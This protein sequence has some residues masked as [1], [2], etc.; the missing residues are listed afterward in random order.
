MQFAIIALYLAVLSILGVY[1]FHRAHLV[2]LFWRYRNNRV[3]PPGEFKDL[4]VVTIQLPMYNELFVAE[5]LLESISELDYPKDKLELQVLDDSTDETSGIVAKKVAE[6]SARGFDISHMH[7]T[8]RTG[9][10]AGALEIGM[11]VARGDFLMVFDADFMPSKDIVRRLIHHFTDPKVAMVQARWDHLNRD[12]SMLTRAQALMLDGHFVIEHIARNRSGRFFNFNGTAGIWRKTA[13]IDAGGWQHDTITEDMDLSFRA[14]I[15]GWKF[16]YVPEAV[17][18]A[19]VPCEMNSFK[20]QQFRWAKGSAQT[21]KKILPM[22]L[23][24]DL[25]LRI[26]LEAIFHLTNNFAYLFLVALACLQLPNMLLRR[27]IDNPMLLLLD[28]PLFLAT[29][30]SIV[31]FYLSTHHFLY[32][33]VWDAVKRL[34]LMMALGIGLSLNN[35]HAVLEGLLSGDAEFVRTAKHGVTKNSDSWKK[36]KSYLGSVNVATVLEILFGLY[37][38]FTI[39]LAAYT[40]A[41]MSIPF[42]VLFMVGFLYVGVL[43]IYQP[44]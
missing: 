25:P 33:S 29:S 3:D 42:L 35:A 16:V 36:N 15:R 12:Y 40:G 32:R 5:R 2:Y 4:P 43:S 8:D 1:G 9:F 38:V 41:W 7:R 37:F 26:K 31:L 30:G 27:D 28:V 24:A 39:G 10:K 23:K 18:P 6:L 20:G 17:A 14:Q 21:T 34:P 44:R 22:V 11:K 13:I 19:E